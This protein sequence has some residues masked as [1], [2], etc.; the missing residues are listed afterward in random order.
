MLSVLLAANDLQAASLT[1]WSESGAYKISI[2]SRD[3]ISIGVLHEWV[4]ELT[5]VEGNAVSPERLAFYGGMPK[6]GHGLPTEPRITE[7]LAPG[8]YLV[9]GVRFNMQGE[10]QIVVGLTGPAGPDKSEF[11]FQIGVDNPV[12]ERATN[13]LELTP[14]ELALLR[15]LNLAAAERYAD[16]SNRFSGDTVASALGEKLFVDPNLSRDANVSCASC[17]TPEYGFSDG[18][19]RS[20]GSAETRRNSQ[21]L[22]G[23]GGA[24]WFYWD[25]RRDSL[26]AQNLTPIE[27]RGEMDNDRVAVLRYIRSNE[28]YVAALQEIDVVLPQGAILDRDASPYGSA[29]EKQRWRAMSPA[30][31]DQINRA[32]SAV[33]KVLAAYVQTL[34]PPPTRFDEL[35]DALSKGQSLRDILSPA[36]ARGLRLFLDVDKTACLRCHNG[37]LLTNFGFHNVGTGEGG[38][39]FDLGWAV[40]QSASQYDAFNCRG[41]YSDASAESCGNLRF[42]N[43]TDEHAAGAFKVPTLRMLGKTGPYMHD[44]RFS[45]LRAVVDFYRER[46]GDESAPELPAIALTDSEADD[47]VAFLLT[48]STD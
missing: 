16:P 27:T 30:Y 43:G 42:A 46:G 26:W 21:T 41:R 35:P 37:P 11:V 10:W 34:T 38:Q 24:D 12:G 8:R 36:E 2:A 31:Q 5:D 9:E 39:G 18:K 23:V 22:F 29:D 25:G 13:L 20:V 28:D 4:I 19:A 40:G 14:V 1:Q 7:R 3:E 32:F 33:G 15:S 47:L 17:H 45:S 48:L 44:G 6:H